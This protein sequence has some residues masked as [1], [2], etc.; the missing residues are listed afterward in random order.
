MLEQG[1]RKWSVRFNRN[2]GNIQAFRLPAASATLVGRG[3]WRSHGLGT[4]AREK[5][6]FLQGK[7]KEIR[8]IALL[9]HTCFSRALT[10]TIPLLNPYPSPRDFSLLFPSSSP[11]VSRSLL[12]SRRSRFH[13][14]SCLCYSLLPTASCSPLQLRSPRSP[15]AGRY[16]H[17][18]RPGAAAALRG[19]RPPPRL[20]R[21]PYNMAAPTGRPQLRGRGSVRLSKRPGARR[22]RPARGS[23]SRRRPFRGDAGSRR[24]GGEAGGGRRGLAGSEG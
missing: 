10:G 4:A 11:P 6:L 12:S 7:K 14:P 8:Q 13:F 3:G 19:R 15:P 20:G 24:A 18:R 16:R 21:L 23:C 17:A 5:P 22:G 1:S 2:L 9:S